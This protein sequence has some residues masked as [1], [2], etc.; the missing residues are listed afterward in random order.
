MP[1]P[2]GPF[3]L[4]YTT[5]EMLDVGGLHKDV[6]GVNR[7]ARPPAEMPGVVCYARMLQENKDAGREDAAPTSPTNT[8]TPQLM[9]KYYNDRLTQSKATSK[10]VNCGG[11]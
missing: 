11:G 8:E 2:W 10:V 5:G 7:R 1:G 3:L 6:A 9:R 4:L